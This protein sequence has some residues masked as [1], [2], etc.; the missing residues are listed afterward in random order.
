VKAVG[1]S[2]ANVA[3]VQ[4]C[5]T[6]EELAVLHLDDPDYINSLDFWQLQPRLDAYIETWNAVK[7]AE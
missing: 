1:Y 5:L 2:P 4:E 6:D 3:A 7:T